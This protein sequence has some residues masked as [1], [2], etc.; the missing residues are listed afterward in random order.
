LEATRRIRALGTPESKNVPIIAMTANVCKEDAEMC[1]SVGRDDHVGKPLDID[2][3]VAKLNK[4]LR[5]AK[6]RA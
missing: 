1:I 6:S 3:V 4:Y 2:E 5:A